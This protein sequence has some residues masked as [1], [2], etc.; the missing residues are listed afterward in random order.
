MRVFYLEY[1]HVIFPF[2]T[3]L[4]CLWVNLVFILETKFR[5]KLKLLYVTFTKIE[6]KCIFLVG[7]MGYQIQNGNAMRII[8]SIYITLITINWCLWDQQILLRVTSKKFLYYCLFSKNSYLWETPKKFFNYRC[9]QKGPWS[10][11]RF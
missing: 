8:F 4:H 10:L 7:L 5:Y 3:A 6:R 2:V 9:F 11:G 1:F